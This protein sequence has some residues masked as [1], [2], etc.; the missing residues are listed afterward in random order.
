MKR[1]LFLRALSIGLVMLGVAASIAIAQRGYGRGSGERRYDPATEMTLTGRVEDVKQQTGRAGGTGTHLL[2]KNAEGMIMEV[3]VGPSAF[4]QKQGLS[5]TTGEQVE[6]T[7][8][9][10]KVAGA[11]V[12]LARQIIKGGKVWTLRD[13]RGIPEWSR[14]RGNGRNRG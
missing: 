11:D 3:H 2:L 6:V 5:F 13:E 14:G 12:L 1:D 9:K 4:L 10:V 7:G 8:S